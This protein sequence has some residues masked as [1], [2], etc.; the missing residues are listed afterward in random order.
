MHTDSQTSEGIRQDVAP[1][2]PYVASASSHQAA[3]GRSDTWR[4]TRLPPHRPGSLAVCRAALCLLDVD[5]R[6]SWCRLRVSSAQSD[7]ALRRGGLPHRSPH[8]AGGWW[9]RPLLW[10]ILLTEDPYA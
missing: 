3:L 4:E 2:A 9:H 8:S 1:H 6:V 7:E 10:P 5:G